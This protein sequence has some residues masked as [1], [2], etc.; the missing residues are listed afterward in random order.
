MSHHI[1]CLVRH[2]ETDWSRDNRLQGNAENS[3]NQSGKQQSEAAAGFLRCRNL[4]CLIKVISSDLPRAAETAKILAAALDVDFETVTALREV[5]FG[6]WT[7][8]KISEVQMTD[9]ECRDWARLDPK[10]QWG[11][12]ESLLEVFE[13]ASRLI[14]SLLEERKRTVF[15]LV[16]HGLVI[17]TLLSYC[18]YG[19]VK[20]LTRLAIG[21]GS[22]TILQQTA[23]SMPMKSLRILCMNWCPSLPAILVQ[24]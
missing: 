13:R 16:T 23:L 11:G 24:T 10:R 1:V 12:G 14:E 21:H 2:G 19:K 18:L 7:G 8:K 5:D 20:S 9:S 15:I 6:E 3:L 4:G 17:Q 22:V